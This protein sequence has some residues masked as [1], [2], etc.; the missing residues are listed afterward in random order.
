MKHLNFVSKARALAVVGATVTTLFAGAAQANLVTN[1]GFETTS[2]AGNGFIG[3]DLTV[4]NW[5]A[6]NGGFGAI[7]TSGAS[8][9]DN[10]VAYNSN[11][12]YLW[13][14]ADSA[15]GGKFVSS[16]ADPAS[17][18]KL[19]QT[20]TGLT[21]GQTYTLSFEYAAAQYKGPAGVFEDGP[22]TSGW[23]VSF[24]T[25][26]FATSALSVVTHGFSGWSTA[27]FTHVATS[28][29]EVLSFMAFGGPAGVPPAA[30][31]D[32]VAVDAAS[33][34]VPATGLL[35][36]LVGLMGLVGRKKKSA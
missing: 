28:A 13:E 11:Q 14:A 16:D 5:T 25:D 33:V 3:T 15:N 8:A 24:G 27:T 10:G 36:G 35:V 2:A 6:A 18:I 22:S 26:N 21:V 12:F 30:L 23:N 4:N 29:S 7:F 19:T 1:G 31:L 20:L 34:P 9:V 32:G 17:A